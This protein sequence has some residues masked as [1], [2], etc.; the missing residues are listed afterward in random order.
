MQVQEIKKLLEANLSGC[1]AHVESEDGHH[2]NARVMAT[3]FIGKTRVQQQRL[4]YSILGAA[5]TNGSIH[6]LSLK[7]FTPEEWQA[8][9]G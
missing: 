3:E 9:H 7:T 1:E 5:I 6:A 2:Y 8:Q 4:V